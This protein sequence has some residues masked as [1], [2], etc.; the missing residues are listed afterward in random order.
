MKLSPRAYAVQ[1]ELHGW[2]GVLFAV[3]LFIA[4]YC[5]V[6]ALFHDE[7]VVWQEPGLQVAGGPPSPT[8]LEQLAADLGAAGVVPP[9]ADVGF[10]LSHD[11]PYVRVSSGE[12]TLGWVDARDG[13][14]LRPRSELADALYGLHFLRPLPVVGMEL[15]GVAAIALLIAAIGGFMLLLGRLRQN[16]WRYRP[17]LRRRWWAADAHKSLGFARAAVRHRDGVVGRDAVARQPDRR[18][19]GRDIL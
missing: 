17:Q 10:E 9:E 12:D 1:W 15:S 4:F 6:F 2:I 7:L 14:L 5:G 18:G 8:E 13:T 19:P 3:P 11:N 16:L